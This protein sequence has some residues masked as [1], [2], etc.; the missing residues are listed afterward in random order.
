[1]A[2]ASTCNSQGLQSNDFL[3]LSLLLHL[4]AL[5]KESTYLS[6]VTLMCSLD[7]SLSLSY[8]LS[9]LFPN[10]GILSCPVS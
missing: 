10:G 4:L 8:P 1:M 9:Q 5:G 7:G 3:I 2:M 6:A